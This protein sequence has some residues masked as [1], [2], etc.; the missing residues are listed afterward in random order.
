MHHLTNKE[1]YPSGLTVAFWLFGVD[2]AVSVT[3]VASGLYVARRAYLR[4]QQTWQD[5]EAEEYS[6]F[7]SVSFSVSA[8]SDS[9]SFFVPENIRHFSN[10]KE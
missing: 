7:S 2:V 4:V 3:V 6:F 10:D 9:A 1:Q 8:S 5:C